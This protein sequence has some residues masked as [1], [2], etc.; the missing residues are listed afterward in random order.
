[1]IG[2]IAIA[3][4]LRGF[5]D[6]GHSVTP[7]FFFPETDFIYKDLLIVQKGTKTERGKFKK[8]QDF[9]PRDIESCHVVTARCVKLWSLNSNL[10]FKEPHQLNKFK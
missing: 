8:F 6:L 10:F 1:M 9:C 5:N 7:T 3:T 4:A 2:K